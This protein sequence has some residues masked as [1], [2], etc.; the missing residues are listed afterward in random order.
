MGQSP[1]FACEHVLWEGTV[2]PTTGILKWFSHLR[3]RTGLHLL[4][5][6]WEWM[7]LKWTFH[8][9]PAWPVSSND[10]CYALCVTCPCWQS[11][12]RNGFQSHLKDSLS[13]AWWM[14]PLLIF[15]VE[16]ERHSYENS[17]N[18]PRPVNGKWNLMTLPASANTKEVGKET[19]KPTVQGEV[20]RVV[21]E[22]TLCVWK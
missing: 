20:S 8:L 16:G 5:G 3:L 22:E 15:C 4:R 12:S 21:A 1:R 2:E 17:K 11:Q 19:W 7:V 18:K 13:Q 10:Q 6:L 9:C 14:H